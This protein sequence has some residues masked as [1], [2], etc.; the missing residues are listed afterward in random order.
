MRDPIPSKRGKRLVDP[1]PRAEVDDELTFHIEQRIRDY[2]ARGMDPVDARAAALERL[3][4]L[5]GVRD[6]CTEL[7]A[8]ERRAAA[9]RDWLGDLRQDLRFGIRG[10]ARAPLFSLL[11]ILTLALGIGANTAIFGVVKSV[12]LDALPYADADRVVRLY[13]RLVDGTSDRAPLS[14]GTV[15][16]IAARQRS[17]S[18]IAAFRGLPYNLAYLGEDGPRVVTTV[19]VEP[20]LFSI[21]GVRP[22]LGRTLSDADT[23][24]GAPAVVMLT[25]STWERLFASDPSVIGRAVRI[26]GVSRTVTGVLPRGF[27]GPLGEAGFYLPLELRSALSDPVRIRGRH[28]LGAVARLEPGVAVDAAQ[29]EAS[30]LAADLARQY[31]EDNGRFGVTVMPVRDALIGSTRT[32]LLVLMGSAGLVLLIA[33]ANLAGALLS[34]AISR[35]KEFVI[36]VALGAGRGRLIRQLLTE[37]IVLALTGGAA[38]FLLAGLGLSVVRT[39]AL[40]ALPDHAELS[41]DAGAMLFTML[42]A[43]C[44]GLAF[45]VAPALSVSRADPQGALRDESRGMSEGRR[46]RRSRGVLVAGQIALCVSLLAGAGLLARSLWAIVDAPLGFTPERVLGV[47]VQ[48]PPG[49]YATGQSRV[50]FMKDLEARV[51]ALPGVVAVASTSD[52]PM[53]VMNRVGFTIVGAPPLPNDASPFVL[54]TGVSDD[55]FRTLGIALLSGRTFAADTRPREQPGVIVSE[56]MARRY[57]PDGK[58]I[59]SRIRMGPDPAS[60][61][62]P[63]VVGIVADV[64]NDPARAEPE[65]QLYVSNREDPWGGSAFVIRTRVD[66]NSL[67]DPVRRELA[68]IDPRLPIDDASSLSAM[69]SERLVGRRLPVVLMTAFGTLALLLASVG[70]YAMFAAMAAARE[71]EFSVRLALGSSRRGIAALVLRQGGVWMALG[72]AGGAV[73]VVIVTRALRGLLYG[74][75]QFDPVALGIAVMTLLVCGT[76]ALLIPVR[77][78][79]RV[80]PMTVLR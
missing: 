32:P 65:P 33:C 9:H 21:L 76:V 73:G 78:A 48:L 24:A 39:L 3:G 51:R 58:A 26:D 29:R 55:Y 56:S 1:E 40:P 61:W 70:V 69:L 75:S 49:D 7:L 71:H 35:R 15:A 43:L 42:L 80:D 23:A 2:I 67:I 37:S 27:I 14:A 6:E 30:A 38:G 64:R 63:E 16:D 57:W 53:R 11:A 28:W 46:S 72:L 52:V 4:D 66:P 12:L 79:T 20:A 41:L 74:V 5:S 59:G 34:R 25:H 50:R 45:G 77:R 22:A 60:P 19:D 44:T 8:A 62:T 13:G 10:A 47:A 36:R 54:Y 17:F 31:P 68:A 18:G